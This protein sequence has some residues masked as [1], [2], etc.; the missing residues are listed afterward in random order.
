MWPARLLLLTLSACLLAAG[1]NKLRNT[2][3]KQVK[4]NDLV[5]VGR[6]YG[7]YYEDKGYAPQ[8]VDDLLP[9]AKG[10]PE[11][12]EA[13]RKVRDGEYVFYWGANL[14]AISR[15]RPGFTSTVLGYEKDVTTEG[16]V[17]VM[18]DY[19]AQEMK[20]PVFAKAAKACDTK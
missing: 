16:G 8:N 4:V 5:T 1:C 12:E 18:A 6:L 3:L 10:N 11:A 20:P 9:L 19:S 2:A 13:L 17:V 7:Q 15:T 14:K